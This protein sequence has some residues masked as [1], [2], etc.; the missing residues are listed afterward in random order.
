MVKQKKENRKKQA[1]VKT[2]ARAYFYN[3]RG[4]LQVYARSRHIDDKKP[5]RTTI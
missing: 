2:R 4:A 3:P 5:K 1:Q